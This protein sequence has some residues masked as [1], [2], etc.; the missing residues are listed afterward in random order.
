LGSTSKKWKN[1]YLNGNIIN[2][3]TLTLPTTTDT[4]VGRQTSDTLS[5]KSLNNSCF[6]VDTT[7]ITKKIAF[8]SSSAVANTTLTIANQQTTTQT[9]SIPNIT[10]ADTIMTLS[11]TQSVGGLKSLLNINNLFNNSTTYSTGTAS[12]TTTTITGSGTTFTS[13]MV[14]GI[15]VFA[16]GTQAFIT[17][18][19]S[20]TSLTVLPSQSVSS[21]S[22]TLYHSGVQM[23]IGNLGVKNLNISGLTASLPVQTDANDNLIS[24]AINLGGSQATGTLANARLVAS[25][26]TQFTSSIDH[27]SLLNY[28]ANRHIDHSA[29]SISTATGLTGG[30]NITATRTISLDINALTEK[31]SP[32]STDF[33][34]LYDVS[35]ISHKKVL[36][37]SVGTLLSFPQGYE[38]IQNVGP[39][40][41]TSTTFVSPT[42]SSFPFTTASKT[43]GTYKVSWCGE[44][45]SSSTSKEATVQVLIDTVERGNI[46][47]YAQSGTSPNKVS[48]AGFYVIIF[49]STATHTL[50]MKFKVASGATAVLNNPRI[51]IYRVA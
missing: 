15:I 21:Q 38:Y 33:L 7:D 40:S 1:L 46:V 20:T 42:G 11:S 18:F 48:V 47:T 45:N 36:L 50:D 23:A 39:Y 17:A 34:L 19:V 43:A 13:A 3:G 4:L 6:F 32:V 49:A 51:E 24:S 8:Q 28:V 12:Q 2:S 31:V 14:G 5:N 25:N 16:N 10:V 35:G 41:T 27:D 26:I 44:L 37:N 29:V 22:F 9:L 30:G